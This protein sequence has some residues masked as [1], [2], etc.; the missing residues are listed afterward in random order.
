MADYYMC[1]QFLEQET[2]QATALS[3]LSGMFS[4]FREAL[5][6]SGVGLYY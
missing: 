3:T 2:E 1:L 4:K 5:S 6:G